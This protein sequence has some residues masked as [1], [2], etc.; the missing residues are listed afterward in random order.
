MSPQSSRTLLRHREE[1][2]KATAAKANEEAEKDYFDLVQT[3]GDSDDARFD[4][5]PAKYRPVQTAAVIGDNDEE[6]EEDKTHIPSRANQIQ[7]TAALIQPQRGRRDSDPSSDRPVMPRLRSDFSR[8]GD[9]E[10]SDSDETEYLPDRFDSQGR[11]LDGSDNVRGFGN[12]GW[13]TR[14]GEFQ[15]QPN[16]SRGRMMDV[17]GQWGIGGRDAESVERIAR[18]VTGILEGRGPS[19]MGIVGGLLRGGLMERLSRDLLKGVDSEQTET[20]TEEEAQR[21][22]RE[23][24]K[25]RIG[26][27]SGSGGGG[28][29]RDEYDDHDQ[30]DDDDEYSNERKRRRQAQSLSTGNRD[31]DGARRSGKGYKGYRTRDWDWD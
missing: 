24:V 5:L 15:Y 1:Q 28:R 22:R 10:L 27:P 2:R 14:R 11:P 6:D 29:Y 4:T 21:R 26:R 31:R 25:A 19:L 9:D 12:G 16:P 23:K 13:H 8:L 30:Y 17:R 20:E 18:N 3:P 7:K